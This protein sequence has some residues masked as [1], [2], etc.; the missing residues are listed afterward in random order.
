[1]PRRSATNGSRISPTPRARPAESCWWKSI[2]KRRLGSRLTRTDP[3]LVVLVRRVRD[4]R[5]VVRIDLQGV[6]SAGIG[7][8]PTRRDILDVCAARLGLRRFLT[9][10]VLD[11]LGAHS[12]ILD[13]AHGASSSEL[14]PAA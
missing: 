4:L 7:A 3:R 10:R 13:S 8:L 6:C 1:M 5:F 14:A 12:L 2:W 9:R 11:A